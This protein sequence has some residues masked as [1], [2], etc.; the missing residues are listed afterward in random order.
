LEGSARDVERSAETLKGSKESC[1]LEM[2]ASDGVGEILGVLVLPEGDLRRNAEYAAFGGHEKRLDVAAVFGV[3]DLRELFPHGA[4]L[5]FLRE[6]FED[7][8][9]IG[10]FRADDDVGVRGDVFCFA[11]ARTAAEPEGML[12]P[13]SPDQH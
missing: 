9:F 3:I 1:G 11:S 8:G 13:D 2:P 6:S 12:P 4:V 5:D 10:F 7:D